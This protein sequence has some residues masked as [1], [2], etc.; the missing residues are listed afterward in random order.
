ML[1][2]HKL[3]QLSIHQ[4]MTSLLNLELNRCMAYAA[5]NRT[6][7]IHT[8]FQSIGHQNY[9]QQVSGPE[10]YHSQMCKSASKFSFP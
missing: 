4:I 1:N 9:L 6:V 7:A 8:P 10:I 5:V 3:Y 2:I